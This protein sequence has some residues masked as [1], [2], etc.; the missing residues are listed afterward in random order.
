MQPDLGR[1]D[2]AGA[3]VPFGGEQA[4]GL[5]EFR[6]DMVALGAAFVI[7]V[8]K[9]QCLT[10]LDGL[11]L[12]DH[13]TLHAVGNGGG[14]VDDLAR[15]LDAGQRGDNGRAGV[16]RRLFD[17]R[18]RLLVGQPESRPDASNVEPNDGADRAQDSQSDEGNAFH[19]VCNCLVL[20]LSP[21]AAPTL[22]R[23][24]T[25]F[26]DEEAVSPGAGCVPL[27]RLRPPNALPSP[28]RRRRSATS[29][30]H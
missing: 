5:V 4:L 10:L 11:A 7:A 28:S 3:D 13:Q 15:R 27:R 20:A 18:R 22:H 6:G 16:A 26:Q 19:E 2:A 30:N 17:G 14:D 1:F 23:R 29:R 25:P 8:E 12:L 21:R 24:K 9:G